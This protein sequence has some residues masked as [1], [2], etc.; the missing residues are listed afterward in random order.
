V[1]LLGA[2]ALLELAPHFFLK[3]GR[4]GHLRLGDVQPERRLARLLG[5]RRG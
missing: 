3:P 5:L 1:D 4:D 2:E